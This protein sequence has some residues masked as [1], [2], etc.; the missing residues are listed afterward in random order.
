MMRA[1]GR[2]QWRRVQTEGPMTTRYTQ[3]VEWA[4]RMPVRYRADVVAMGEGIAGV[5]AACGG[6]LEP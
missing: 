5:R 2:A 3:T 4:R 6:R 1:R